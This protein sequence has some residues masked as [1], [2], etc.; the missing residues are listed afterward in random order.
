MESNIP[1]LPI[2]EPIE[3]ADETSD[4]IPPQEATVDKMI[5]FRTKFGQIIAASQSPC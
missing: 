1:N 2:L 4:T 3:R 5:Q